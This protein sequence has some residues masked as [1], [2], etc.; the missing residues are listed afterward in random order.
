M[1]EMLSAKKPQET[2]TSSLDALGKNLNVL[3]DMICDLNGMLASVMMAPQL[4]EN[5]NS[6][7]IAS[8]KAGYDGLSPVTINIQ[9]INDN[10]I[11]LIDTVGYM[12]RNLN[13]S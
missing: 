12:K 13:I 2:V 1:S 5:K 7:S 10:V 4:E 9:S 3:K 8:I 6:T 11:T